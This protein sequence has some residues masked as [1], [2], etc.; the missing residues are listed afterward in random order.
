LQIIEAIQAR[1]IVII[2]GATGCGKTTQIPK[3]IYEADRNH[4]N[5]VVTQPRRIA[6][7]SIAKRVAKE[8]NC[9]VG[10]LV[11]YQVLR[12]FCSFRPE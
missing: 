7:M 5:V 10:S 1:R 8:M 11:G 4:N 9:P 12:R 6:A 2:K 3:L